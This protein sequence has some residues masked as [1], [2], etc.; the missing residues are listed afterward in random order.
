MKISH[1]VRPFGRGTTRSLGD[2]PSPWL[3]TTYPSHGMILQVSGRK[4]R[5]KVDFPLQVFLWGSTK[6]RWWQLND[7]LFSPPSLG[8][9]DAIWRGHIFANGLV[10]NHQLEKITMQNG[11]GVDFP[12]LVARI[13][14]LHRAPWRI[15]GKYSYLCR[16]IYNP[17]HG[18]Y[19]GNGQQFFWGVST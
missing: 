18:L 4:L 2:L 14:R 12:T 15:H 6:T 7:F 5:V 16:W 11:S 3:L 10:K 19:V 9:H 17:S 13:P 8:F 1:E